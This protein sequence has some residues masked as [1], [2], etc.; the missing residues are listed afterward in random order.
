MDFTQVMKIAGAALGAQSTRIRVIAE[1]IANTDTVYK[2]GVEPYRRKRVLFESVLDR[3]NSADLVQ[4]RE[5]AEQNSPPV[6]KFDPNHPY[7]DSQGYVS[8]P[9]ISALVEIADLRDAERSYKA[10]V[11][12]VEGAKRFVKAMLDIIR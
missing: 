11:Q 1:N 5:I 12:V 9:D 8:Y 4:V 7:A 2:Q 6:K 10:N 3:A